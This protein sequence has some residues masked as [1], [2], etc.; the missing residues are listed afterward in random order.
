M[1]WLG[2]ARAR[3]AKKGRIGSEFLLTQPHFLNSFLRIYDTHVG[4]PFQD[5][6]GVKV[7][8]RI[9]C[10]SYTADG[11]RRGILQTLLSCLDPRCNDC[12]GQG[13]GTL[14]QGGQSPRSSLH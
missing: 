14:L 8:Y 4:N 10:A 12:L 11:K 7:L 1:P 2:T 9:Q 13:K 6:L 3:A 5:E